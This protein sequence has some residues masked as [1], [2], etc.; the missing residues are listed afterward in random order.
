MTSDLDKVRIYIERAKHEGLTPQEIYENL[1]D[2]GVKK[3]IV[4]AELGMATHPDRQIKQKRQ[5][6]K[7]GGKMI[8]IFIFLFILISITLFAG[9]AY[10]YLNQSQFVP[11]NQPQIESEIEE[12]QSES[13]SS[14][15]AALEA[16]ASVV[17]LEEQ[18]QN[19]Y[20]AY[21]AINED[22]DT[23]KDVILFDIQTQERNILSL[24]IE[25]TSNAEIELF[26]WSP[27]QQFLPILVY[28]GDE[29]QVFFYD[30]ETNSISASDSIT[31]SQEDTERFRDIYAE[32][33][34]WVTNDVFVLKA[35]FQN[36]VTIRE[37]TGTVFMYQFTPGQQIT[38]VQAVTEEI[39]TPNLYT[40]FDEGDFE[41]YFS[42]YIRNESF[43]SIDINTY[44]QREERLNLIP[45]F[46]FSDDS[47]SRILGSNS[48]TGNSI[49]FTIRTESVNL[50]E[51]SLRSPRGPLVPIEGD[52]SENETD[53]QQTLD[54]RLFP[55]FTE[56]ILISTETATQE[57]QVSD[58]SSWEIPLPGVF[59][60][61]YLISEPTGLLYGYT[62][63][64]A[65]DNSTVIYSVYDFSEEESTELLEL[66][67]G[68]E[69]S[70]RSSRIS[71]SGNFAVI[72]G[73]RLQDGDSEESEDSN[74]ND[75]IYRVSLE[76]GDTLVVCE[77]NCV[78]VAVPDERRA[79]V[80][81]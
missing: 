45:F 16:T 20:I 38:L 33:Y 8:V 74:E 27:T 64:E 53:V 23:K 44:L 66:T 11:N 51:R 31:M 22:E 80:I 79:R 68:T 69:S 28:E 81:F 55:F 59:R 71:W 24:P 2:A 75:S 49:N 30:I 57:A 37:Q 63:D 4:E 35:T 25:F 6:G 29:G 21:V 54:V 3:E 1:R 13:E 36:E 77:E 41:T 42:G 61:A 76:T 18:M 50:Q 46:L 14:P 73:Q 70:V 40:P 52:D 65:G 17:I 26:D 12:P 19:P 5:A 62:P 58:I 43:Y 34:G 47:Q 56:N 72:Y 9:G 60:E 15:E 48:E 7:G 39:E 32:G 78:D 67:V 10:I